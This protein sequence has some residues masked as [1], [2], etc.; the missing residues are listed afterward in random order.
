MRLHPSAEQGQHADIVMRRQLGNSLSYLRDVCA[1]WLD[2]GEATALAAAAEALQAGRRLHPAVFGHYAQWVQA[3]VQ[4]D[5]DQA[6]LAVKALLNSAAQ[7]ERYASCVSLDDPELDTSRDIITTLMAAGDDDGMA[8]TSPQPSALEH[9]LR[10][11]DEAWV[12]ARKRVPALAAEIQ[13]LVAQ[14]VLVGNAPEASLRF[15]GGSSYML[16]GA[17]LI[18]ADE[19]RSPVAMLELL[20]HESAHLLLYAAAHA[21]PLVANPEEERYP[22]PLRED[23]RPMDG[24]Y[25]ATWV[26]ARMAWAMHQLAVH[27]N[28]PAAQAEEARSALASDLSHFRA[29]HAVVQAHG[30]LTPTGRSVMADASSWVNALT[31]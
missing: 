17:L 7:G 8:L 25:H 2:A 1:S 10:T 28:T 13:T 19:Q 14:T 31:A 5:Q 20:A 4:E 18:N 12:L 11:L 24:I 3:L 29:G 6:R 16:W 22:S 15:D 27:P 21:E 30:R 26:S 9:T 23:P